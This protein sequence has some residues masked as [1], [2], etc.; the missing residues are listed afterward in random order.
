[1]K[2][3][4]LF[5]ILF[6][7][8]DIHASQQTLAMPKP[9]KPVRFLQIDLDAIDNKQMEQQARN[10]HAKNKIKE[11]HLRTHFTHKILPKISSHTSCTI[12]HEDG[13][14]ETMS[15]EK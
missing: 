7:A 14:T 3:F 11:Q 8:L 5:F 9:I 2:K 6:S 12:H 15:L 10:L 13:A 4:F 1:M